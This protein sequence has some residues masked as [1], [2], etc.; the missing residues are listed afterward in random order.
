MFKFLL[1][2]IFRDRHRYLFPLLI[3]SS[4]VAIMIFT[5]AFMNGYEDSFIRQNARFETGHLKIVTNAYAEM[6]SMK[7]FD[8]G[9]LEIEAELEEWKAAYPQVQWVQR[10]NFGALLDVPDAN[11]ETRAQGEVMGFA[12]DLLRF[13]SEREYLHLDESLVKGRLPAKRGEALVSDSAFERLGLHLGDEVTLI[14]ST[15]FGAMS[16][17]NFIVSGTVN[18]G[19]ESLDRGAVIAD[20]QDVRV[21]LDMEGGAGEILGFLPDGIYDQKEADR[22]KAD[23]NRRFSGDDEFDPVMLT[24]ADQGIMGY[25][26][27]VMSSTLGIM[28]LVLTIIL[29]IVLWNSGL[30]N[31]IRRYGE[32][33]VRLAIGERKV[34]VYRGLVAEAVVIGIIGSIIGAGLGLLISLYFNTHGM[35]VS[36]YNRSSSILSENMIYTSISI[37][38]A[39]YGFIPGVLSTVLGAALAG[40]AI[41]RRQTSQ[42]FKELEV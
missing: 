10:I 24:L 1:K 3:V 7:P 2:G 32:F 6:I 9:L 29:G 8:L 15:V 26:I 5:M 40:I 12:V 42:L 27:R 38:T 34:H 35:D 18:F 16:M 4:G 28:S 14:G 36:A 31:G 19:V 21:M 37:Y 33:G 11:L 20:I 22:V 25:L 39:F 17:Q 13:N 41:F 23:F 30:M